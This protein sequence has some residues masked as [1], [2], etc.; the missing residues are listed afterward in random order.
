M[1]QKH[2][3]FIGI[4]I[5]TFLLGTFAYPVYFN[6]IVDFLN[7]KT[8]GAFPHFPEK[9]FILGLDLQGGVS[10][11]Y[12]AD[13]STVEDKIGAMSGLRDVIERRINMF[14]VSEPVVQI[15]GENRLLVEMPGVTDVNQAISMIGQTPYL[16]FNEQRDE[17][18]TKQILEKISE[19][20]Q[21][22]EK[23][24]DISTVQNRE[25]ILQN[26]YFK[27]TKLTGQYL[28]K[29]NVVFDNTTF[30]PQIE[31]QF[32]DEG[33]KIFEEITA[34]NINKQLAIFLDG[35]SIIDTNS[36]GKIDA[37]DLYAP[38]VRE[39]ITGGKAVIT[40]DINT[41][42]ANIIASRLNSGALPV[43]IGEPISQKTVGPTLGEVSLKMS[44][45]AAILGFLALLVYFMIFYRLSGIIASLSMIFYIAVILSIIKIFSI[46]LT[47]S[48]I[49]GILLS[50]GMAVDANILI[51][52]RMREELKTGKSF[53]QSISDGTKRAWP[54]IR[55]GNVT[56]ILVGLVLFFLGT[57]FVKGFALTLILG[58]VIG[59]L[60][61]IL[62]TNFLL[63]YFSTRIK[64][65]N[66]LWI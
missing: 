8:G 11:V 57:S 64:K 41:Q 10:L 55:D 15:Q 4:I 21:A 48:G 26:P 49:A 54:S 36:D 62:L 47:L 52:S 3:I 13:L 37:N 18:E 17:E 59:A 7:S 24:Q 6:K 58:N 19:V 22:Q 32:N 33:A 65:L 53:S 39:K 14:G 61:A 42:I 34:R 31:L 16:E 23:G 27:P 29:A 38:V 30:K 60:T 46:T 9:S 50:M 5:F 43:K 20:Q 63:S 25:T 56:T 2:Y 12:E 1:Q 44:L 35:S 66:K 45:I 51:F 28:K 40:G